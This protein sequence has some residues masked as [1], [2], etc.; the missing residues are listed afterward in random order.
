VYQK[1]TLVQKSL[2]RPEGTSINDAEQPNPFKTASQ[3]PSHYTNK[4]ERVVSETE[5]I[6]K[7][8]NIELL[9]R[10]GAGWI[11]SASSFPSFFVTNIC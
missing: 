2:S 4:L 1:S 6:K 3:M 5:N 8:E 11:G 7:F 10:L 9:Q